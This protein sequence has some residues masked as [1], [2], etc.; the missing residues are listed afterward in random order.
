VPLLAPG[1][2]IDKAALDYIRT[3]QQLGLKVVGPADST[4]QT[5]KVVRDDR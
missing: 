3:M 4:L 2:V 5:I 1:D